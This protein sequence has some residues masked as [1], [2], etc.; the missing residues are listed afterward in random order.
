MR[1]H[2]TS[3]RATQTETAQWLQRPLHAHV[4]LEERGVAVGG[5]RVW[6]VCVRVVCVCV[7][8]H[9]RWHHPGKLKLES[10]CKVVV[11]TLMRHQVVTHLLTHTRTRTYTLTPRQ[12]GIEWLV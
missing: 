2:T 5:S 11:K 8:V 3:P 12:T 9:G 4:A 1:H 6:C 10:T 7:C